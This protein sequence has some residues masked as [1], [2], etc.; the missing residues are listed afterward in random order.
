VSDDPG[1]EPDYDEV[2]AAAE[3]AKSAEID[4]NAQDAR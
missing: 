3:D 1:V 4:A 2:A